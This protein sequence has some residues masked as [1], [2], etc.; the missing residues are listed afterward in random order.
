MPSRAPATRDTS[1]VTYRAKR[2]FGA[3]P[4]PAP[5][6]AARLGKALR[7]VVQKH[8][9]RRLHWDFR[10]EHE[11]V[12]WS[13]AVP[14]G[15]SLDP[16][17][18]RLAVRVE[19]H[20]LDY[21]NFHGSIPEG[22]YGAGT[23]AIWDSGS[24]VP[25]GDAAADLAKGELKF[26]VQGARLSG[27]FV[28]VRL[29]RR[30]GDKADNWLL[31]KEH[32]EAERTGADAGMLE[33]KPAPKGAK[34]PRKAKP[35][36]VLEAEAASKAAP[37]AAPVARRG[38]KA[39]PKVVTAG[40]PAP[41]LK[42]SQGAPAAG[43]VPGPLPE[44]QRP[45]LATLV[46]EPPEGEE[47]LSEVK[48][49]GYRLLARKHGGSVHLTTRNGLDWTQ[50]LPE[51]A[52]SIARLKPD[53]LLL[54]GELVAL[55]PDGLSSFAELQAALAA[56]GKRGALYFYTF[57][58]LHLDGWD[59]R[60]CPLRDRKALLQGLDAWQG[61]LRYSDH[62]SG[63]TPQV[64]RQACQMGLEGIICKRAAA[65]YKGARTRDWVK[66]KCQGRDE[67]I[68]LGWTPPAGSRQPHRTGRAAP[69]LP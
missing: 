50:K 16:H 64:R 23:V 4:E 5:G 60:P 57:D 13:W 36:A 44:D 19:D 30:P 49:D 6:T 37:T 39:Q 43:A 3:T 7:F 9:A 11:G 24:W 53:S 34:V 47:W 26:T 35:Q 54:D 61:A 2:D 1:I 52:R 10:L 69:G 58:L 25:L 65:P 14:K 38:A 45:Q 15:P 40:R 63:A 28:L 22:H 66:V 67:F 68:V 55:R 42:P 48:F 32:D 29:K 17:D 41:K 62:L 51:L 8:D 56:G 59:L 18:K 33:E 27:G 20:P 12:L 21:A 31:I 46:E